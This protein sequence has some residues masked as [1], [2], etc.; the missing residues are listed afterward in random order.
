MLGHFQQK[1]VVPH[2]EIVGDVEVEFADGDRHFYVRIFIGREVSLDG[3]PVLVE[4]V[5]AWVEG[6]VPLWTE[7]R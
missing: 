5:V 2:L 6:G 7:K 1:L 4:F 3:V